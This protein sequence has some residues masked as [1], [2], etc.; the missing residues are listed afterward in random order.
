M[1]Y[2]R[3]PMRGR[4]SISPTTF[5]V[6]VLLVAL[7]AAPLSL[8]AAGQD[9]YDLGADDAWKLIESADPASPE[10]Q[11]AAARRALADKQYARAKQIA[12]NWLKQYP[13]HA[14][15]PLA[16]LTR[17]DARYFSGDEYKALFDYET[18]ARVYPGSDVFI[19]ALEREL[20]IGRDYARGGKRR[21][22][23]MRIV[24]A[25]SEGEELLIRVQER[26]PGSNLAEEAG[27]ELGDFYFRRGEMRLAAD[28]YD[29]FIQNY[30]DS[31][32][33]TR[34]RQRLIAAHLASSKGPAFDATGLQN[35]RE[36]LREMRVLEPAAAE[37]LGAEGLLAGIDERMAAKML[38]TA[39]YY[40][41]TNDVIAADL[42][43][44][45][46]LRKYERTIAATEAIRLA[47]QVIERL[48][49]NVRAE[50]E[51]YY[52][53]KRLAILG[54]GEG[55]HGADTAAPVEPS[56]TA[57]ADDGT[58]AGGA[59]GDSGGGPQP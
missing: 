4:L 12:D 2:H 21:L 15:A 55:A 31:P 25:S 17:G 56:D 45:R 28:A 41:K 58:G 44:R 34:A 13:R 46:L 3:V 40:L 57:G 11:L 30:P 27:M 7:L 43:L 33:V 54:E 36:R 18:I 38:V 14:L 37:Q 35:A 24:G 20:A 5:V 32:R 10:G 29:L 39:R 9:T 50:A 6:P 47:P 59:S 19:T 1:P 16:Y 52:A 23:G 48:S 26:L 8:R 53:A 51:P 42:T 22:W 49:A